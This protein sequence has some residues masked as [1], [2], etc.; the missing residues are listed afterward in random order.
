MIILGTKL[1]V[2]DNSG[3]K[4]AQCIGIPGGARIRWAEVGEIIT[5]AVKSATPNAKVS[6][7][8]VHRAVIVRTKQNI[9]RRDGSNIS[10]NSNAVVILDKK[11]EPIGTRIFGPVAREVR[12]GGYI[13]IASLASE[14]L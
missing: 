5:V 7:S 3:A 9:K 12:N 8:E 11:N 10:F 2:A 6:K 1:I 14:V 13:R 4:T